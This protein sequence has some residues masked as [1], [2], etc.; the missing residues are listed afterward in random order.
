MKSNS[1]VLKKTKH[2]FEWGDAKVKRLWACEKRGCVM[3][4]LTTSK[5]KIEIYITKTGKVRIWSK[6]GKENFQ[7]EYDEWFPTVMSKE[8]IKK[9]RKSLE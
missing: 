2:G 9:L 6:D 1:V 4:A 7:G 3:L 8:L 5:R